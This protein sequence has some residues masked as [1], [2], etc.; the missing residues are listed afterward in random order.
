M[1]KSVRQEFLE[2]VHN[3][4]TTNLA[5]RLVHTKRAI[6]RRERL[7]SKGLPTLGCIATS[8]RHAETIKNEILKRLKEQRMTE[9]QVYLDIPLNALF[10]FEFPTIEARGQ[11]YKK[12]SNSQYCRIGCHNPEYYLSA[13]LIGP[14]QI[15]K[16]LD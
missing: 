8:C 14:D 4:T 5:K 12:I 7:M 11:I 9:C 3:D 1:T 15:I 16:P 10:R 6:E 2:S 13:N